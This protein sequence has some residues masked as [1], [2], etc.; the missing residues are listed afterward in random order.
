[1]KNCARRLFELRFQNFLCFLGVVLG[2]ALEKG[3]YDI[4]FVS[5][6]VKLRNV[7]LVVASLACGISPGEDVLI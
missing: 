2:D 6:L 5:V 1:M 3:T 7:D 4:L